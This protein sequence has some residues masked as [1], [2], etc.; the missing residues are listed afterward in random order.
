MHDTLT[1]RTRDI[2]DST[3]YVTPRPVRIAQGW[4]YVQAFLGIA[5]SVLLVALLAPSGPLPGGVW[6]LIVCPS[7]STS[8]SACWA[9]CST[10]AAAGSALRR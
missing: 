10:R 6:A 1:D 5:A 2:H 4:M 3:E 9:G 7:P 8:G